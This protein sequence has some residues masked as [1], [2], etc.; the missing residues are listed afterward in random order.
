MDDLHNTGPESSDLDLLAARLRRER[1]QASPLELDHIKLE[2]RRR[3]DRPART[4][5]LIPKGAPMKSRIAVTAILVVGALM[6]GTGAT[7]AITGPSGVGA[8]A[9]QNQYVAGAT[10]TGTN[11]TSTNGVAGATTTGTTPT[12]GEPG[13]VAGQS[14]KDPD[15]QSGVGG[16]SGSSE[17]TVGAGVDDSTPA[18]EVQANRQEGSEDSGD[19]P[20]TGFAALPVLLAGV[21]LLITGVLLRRRIA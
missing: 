17:P 2:A 3:A 13:T 19:L 9:A 1:P 14:A 7:L 4:A 21:A 10:T 11:P 18:A 5:P 8:N 15:G 16:V 12:S 20:F 6:S